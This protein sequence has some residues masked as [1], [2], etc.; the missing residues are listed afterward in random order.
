VPAQAESDGTVSRSYNG[1]WC[2]TVH[3]FAVDSGWV[4][5]AKTAKTPS[6]PGTTH[7]GVTANGR[8]QD[9]P[10]VR[11]GQLQ[12]GDQILV[13]R[14]QRVDGVEIHQRSGSLKLVPRQIRPL[15]QEG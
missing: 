13:A 7:I 4:F 15:L 6:P 9:V 5:L 3:E 12:T 10:V 14:Y 8:G 1:E 11:I 2:H